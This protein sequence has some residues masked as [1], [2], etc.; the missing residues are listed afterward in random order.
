MNTQIPGN[1]QQQFYANPT[2]LQ[3][4]PFAQTRAMVISK[5]FIYRE[6]QNLF[7]GSFIN[8]Y[9]STNE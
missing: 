8:S 1:Y 6:N 5:R 7:L 2:Y 3:Q 9:T 4:A